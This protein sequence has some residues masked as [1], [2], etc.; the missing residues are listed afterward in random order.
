VDFADIK[1]VMSNSGTAMLGVG[2]GAGPDRALQA[3][4]AATNAPLIQS[5]IERA[6]SVRLQCARRSTVLLNSAG[7]AS[8][9]SW[10]HLWTVTYALLCSCTALPHFRV[11]QDNS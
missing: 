4:Y 11:M 10:C 8:S 3:A 2:C 7:A 1:A 6:V 9:L 5:T